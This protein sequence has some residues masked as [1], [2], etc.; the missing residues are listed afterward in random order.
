MLMIE[1]NTWPAAAIDAAFVIAKTCASAAVVVLES[2]D[3]VFVSQNIP[4]EFIP[5]KRVL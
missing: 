3:A 5:L 4:L 1:L 2:G